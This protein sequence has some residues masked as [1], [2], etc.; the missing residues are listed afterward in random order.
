MSLKFFPFTLPSRRLR[1][2]DRIYVHVYAGYLRCLGVCTHACVHA[3]TDINMPKC[4]SVD[5]WHTCIL[6]Y[7][8]ICGMY[9]YIE[10]TCLRTFTHYSLFHN[11]VLCTRVPV[12][13][14]IRTTGQTFMCTRMATC[15]CVHRLTCTGIH[16]P[17]SSSR[18]HCLASP[19]LCHLE[20]S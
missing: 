12:H 11:C 18:L 1:V 7:V 2:S 8:R 20:A 15:I 13:T 17:L 19:G 14:H 9:T 10:S 3:Y 4:V 16:T 6:W 5:M